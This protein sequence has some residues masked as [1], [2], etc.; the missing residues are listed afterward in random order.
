[1]CREIRGIGDRVTLK[2]GQYRRWDARFDVRL[3]CASTAQS[4]EVFEVRRLGQEGW[5]TVV[6]HH[7]EPINGNVEIMPPAVRA[8]LP[9]LWNQEELVDVPHLDFHRNGSKLELDVH[10]TPHWPLE[11]PPFSV[12]SVDTPPI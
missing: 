4:A 8:T 10:F 3:R 5:R 12:V 7:E 11:F 9:A 6:A 1:M 2:P